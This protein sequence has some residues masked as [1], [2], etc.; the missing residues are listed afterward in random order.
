MARGA[1]LIIGLSSLM[2]TS[3]AAA[4]EIPQGTHVLLRMV[5]SVSTRTA[6]PGDRVYLE[7]ASPITAGGRIAVPVHSYV[8]GV[9]THSKRAGRV[10]GKAQLAVRRATPPTPRASRFS[11]AAAPPSAGSW[12]ATGVA[13]ASAP[14]RAPAWASPPSCSPA[15]AKSNFRAAQPWMWSSTAPFASKPASGPVVSPSKL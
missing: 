7:T 11:P 9:V 12:T 4:S 8:Q 10:R 1:A 6:R 13:R 14:G 15:A 2:F 5:N 3:G